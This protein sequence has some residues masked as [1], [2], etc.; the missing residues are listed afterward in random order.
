MN[1]LIL[2]TFVMLYSGLGFSAS[3]F[4]DGKNTTKVDAVPAITKGG[5]GGKIIKVTNLNSEGEGSFR[6]AVNMD[7]PRIIVFEVGGVIDLDKSRIIIDKPYVTIAGQT[8]PSPGITFIRGG[9]SVTTHDVIIRHIMVRPGDAGEPKKSGWEPDG[10]ATSGGNAFNILIDHCSVT[11]SVDENISASGSRL[12]GPENTSHKV[13]ISNCLI[14]EGLSN[15]THAKGEH[16]KGSLIHDNCREIT[17]QRNLFAHNKQRNPYF[18]TAATGIIANNVIYNPGNAAIHTHWIKSE[19]EGHPEPPNA[20][21]AIVGNVLIPGRDTKIKAFINGDHAELFLRENYI[22]NNPSEIPIA[23]GTFIET[24]SPPFQIAGLIDTD[25]V[26]DYILT[27][28]GARPADRDPIDQ[29]IIDSVKNKQ[30]RII[31]SQDEVE[32]YPKYAPVYRELNIPG[33]N[34]QKWLDKMASLVE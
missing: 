1:K 30:G 18:K 32:G 15:S 11:W 14:A 21:I 34:I 28:A 12:E 19:W 4:T 24:N 8:A 13:T 3:I 31:D 2:M 29:R 16:S 20:K 27:R 17:V 10:I 9:I 5:Q 6:E 22:E 33:K 23:A 25:E 7:G 26:T